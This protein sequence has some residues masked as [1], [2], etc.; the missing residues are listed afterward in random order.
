ME[1]WNYKK[2]IQPIKNQLSIVEGSLNHRI[3]NK[4]L[5]EKYIEDVVITFYAKPIIFEDPMYGEM[6]AEKP[7]L[8][9]EQVYG[10]QLSIQSI[11]ELDDKI[12]QFEPG[13]IFGSFSN[14]IDLMPIEV[15]FNK[16]DNKRINCKGEISF[17]NRDESFEG[18]FEDHAKNPIF[19]NT[20]L[21]I[22]PLVYLDYH[23]LI[24]NKSELAKN[25]NSNIYNLDKIQEF[26]FGWKDGEMKAYKI[27][28]K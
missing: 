9:F 5:S 17:T 23:N 27:E 4:R 7:E 6:E 16:R 13:T 28:L 2:H 15:K 14:E 19:I 21:R 26:D 1:K 12:Y 24:E 10:D 20:E 11:G 18:T 3:S 22:E 8:W 25:L